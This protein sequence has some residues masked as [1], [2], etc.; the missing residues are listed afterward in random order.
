M[1]KRR[2]I[3]DPVIFIRLAALCFVRNALEAGVLAWNWRLTIVC[4]AG[5]QLGR[6]RPCGRTRP[7]ELLA[8]AT[9]T[10]A[11]ANGINRI[12]LDIIPI[13]LG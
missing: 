8:T 13:S 3:P 1:E 10:A 4:R 7:T 9:P 5:L 6:A 11:R 2:R 12:T